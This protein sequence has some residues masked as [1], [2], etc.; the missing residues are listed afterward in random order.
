MKQGIAVLAAGAVA[1]GL[2]A[3]HFGAGKPGPSYPR[4]SDAASSLN[5]YISSKL[6]SGQ[7]LAG[8]L[9]LGLTPSGGLYANGADRANPS[10]SFACL[11][12]ITAGAARQCVYLR[13]RLDGAGAVVP[14]PSGQAVRTSYCARIG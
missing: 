11:S 13:V 14:K 10:R 4:P 6:P 9:C 2:L 12:L 7:R 5:R 1:A 8:S 3:L